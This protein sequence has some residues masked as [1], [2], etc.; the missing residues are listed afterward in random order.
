MEFLVQ[1]VFQ[2]PPQS[3]DEALII[4]HRPESDHRQIIVLVHGLGGTRYGPKCTWGNIPSFL[5]EDFPQL[6]VGLYEYRTLFRRWKLWESVAL[7]TEARTFANLLRENHDYAD[8]LLAG[9]SLGGLLCMG[10]LQYFYA[11]DQRE[12]LERIRGLYLM[13]TPQTGSQR[14]PRLLS[15]LSKDFYALRPHGR[16]VTDV[17]RTLTNAFSLD[18]TL[19]SPDRILIPTWALLGNSDFWV[20][21]LS[22]GLNLPDRRCMPVRGSHTSIVKPGHKKSDGYKFLAERIREAL[23]QKSDKRFPQAAWAFNRMARLPLQPGSPPPPP[24]LFI[25]REESLRDLKQRLGIAPTGRPASPGQPLTVIRGLPG[26]GK[27][28]IARALANDSQVTN[29]FPPG[30]LLWAAIGQDEPNLVSVIASWGS[31]LYSEALLQAS[32]LQQAMDLLDWALRGRRVLFI[33][34]DV[35]RNEDAAPFLNRG[36]DCTFVITTR[37]PEVAEYITAEKPSAIYELPRLTEDYAFELFVHLAPD[38][39]S[40]YPG[41]SR[42]LVRDLEGLPLALHVAGRL[43]NSEH[44]IGLGVTKLLSELRAGKQLLEANAPAD[45]IELR[46]QTIPTVDALL[47]KSTDCLD[48]Y[49]RKCFAQLGLFPAKPATFDEDA[50]K[51]IWEVDEPRHIISILVNRGLLEPDGTGRFQMHALLKMHAQSF[52]PPGYFPAR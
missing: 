29:R 5:F 31:I 35:W 8:I 13:A 36:G 1:S 23:R 24:S 50:M 20:D 33:I 38:V 34:D 28:V 41:E 40:E 52:F 4:H 22:A 32:T 48:E 15:W 19:T 16:F 45:R 26:L 51:E 25:G 17:Q 11:S 27:T 44:K 43:L 21:R 18:E 49:T 14:V 9:H 2:E 3:S 30:S 10:A 42:E 39:A 6:D 47:R 46:T 7:E 37:L 12:Q